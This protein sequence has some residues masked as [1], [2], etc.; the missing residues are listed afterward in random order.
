L[1]DVAE[2]VLAERHL[3]ADKKAAGPDL[4]AIRLIVPRPL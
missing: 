1:F 3:V 2:L 4:A